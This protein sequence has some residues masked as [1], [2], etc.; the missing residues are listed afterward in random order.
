MAMKLRSLDEW[1]KFFGKANSD[2]FEVIQHAIM[3]AASDYPK[4]F[5]LR[6]DQIAATLFS[7]KSTRCFG[8]DHVELL[9]PKDEDKSSGVFKSEFDRDDHAE[10]AGGCK[11]MNSCRDDHGEMTINQAS[12]DNC[13]EADSLTD[14]FEEQ[15]VEEVLMIKDLLD[16]EQYE[17]DSV[18]Y[19]SLKRLQLIPLSMDILKATEIGKAV[20]QIRKT[21]LDKQ[22]RHVAGTLILGWR[23]I[24]DEWVATV[25]GNPDSMNPKILPPKEQKISKETKI[26]K[27]SIRKTPPSAPTDKMQCSGEAALQLKLEASKRKLR[28]GYQEAQNAKKQRKIQV[29][30]LQ[31]LPK[32]GL[33]NKDPHVTARNHKRWWAY[34]RR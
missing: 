8:C 25:E 17:T 11:E 15:T 19:D 9:L 4:E 14:E 3:M 31:D 24:V 29:M 21:H 22:I 16:N 13:R 1:R 10:E 33:E 26:K 12:N 34:R 2:I 7:C 18:I 6:R 28:D 20:N 5:R 27:V 23:I 32:Q 30:E